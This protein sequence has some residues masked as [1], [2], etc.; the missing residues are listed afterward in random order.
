MTR[1]SSAADKLDDSVNKVSVKDGRVVLN[2][3]DVTVN[4]REMQ[5]SLAREDYFNFGRLLG[6]V[7]QRLQRQQYSF[8][9]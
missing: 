3:V 6:D 1:L 7:L 9:Q 2:N 8:L 5:E 4:M